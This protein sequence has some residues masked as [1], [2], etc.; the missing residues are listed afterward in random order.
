MRLFSPQWAEA[1]REVVDRG[2]DEAIRATKLASYWEWID[3]ARGSYSS[4]WALGLVETG[5]YLRLRWAD[6]DCVEASIR[7]EPDADYVLTADAAAWRDIITGEDAGRLLMYRRMRLVHGD[8]LLFFR[9]IYF[10]VESIAAI[11]RIPASMPPE[12]APAG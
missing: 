12:A 4:S 7:E 6:G 11:G 2:P 3:R 1:A 9:G 8:V 5:Q 10:V